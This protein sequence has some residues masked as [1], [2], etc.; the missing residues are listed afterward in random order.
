MT[1]SQEKDVQKAEA[2]NSAE[3]DQ[4]ILFSFQ[5][6]Y[7]IFVAVRPNVFF[8]VMNSYCFN[9]SILAILFFQ[10]SSKKP[11]LFNTKKKTSH[12]T[13]V[14]LVILIRD[15]LEQAGKYKHKN[16]ICLHLHDSVCNLKM[17]TFWNQ[18]DIAPGC[19]CA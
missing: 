7:F 11:Y 13:T 12:A 9:E 19:Q 16:T 5:H 8:F 4:I 2:A 18:M 1:D 6:F 15:H 14:C 3:K 10:L 17:Q